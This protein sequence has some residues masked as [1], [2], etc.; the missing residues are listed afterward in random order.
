V[1]GAGILFSHAKDDWQ[2]PRAF[3]EDQHAIHVFTIDG[4]ASEQNTLLPRWW[5][6]GALHEDAL[7]IR[8]TGERVWCNPPYSRV[9][10][11]V[12]KAALGEAD[13]AMLLVPARTDTRWWHEHIWN[14]IGP[15]PGVTVQFVKG[16]MKF[17][18]PAQEVHNSAPFPSVLVGFRHR[19][20]Q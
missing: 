13:Y 1:K 17:I 4:A 19:R 6:P 15:K 8:W 16:R 7:I 2:T 12:A 5:G 3:F 20:Y 10:E 14:G 9:A 11:F 18:N